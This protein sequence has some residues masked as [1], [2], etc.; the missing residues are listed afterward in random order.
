MYK[1]VTNDSSTYALACLPFEGMLEKR[2]VQKKV[3][4]LAFGPEVDTLAAVK[5][6]C[7]DELKTAV[8]T[9]YEPELRYRIL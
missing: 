8:L 6:I 5:E 7:C 1:L 2:G 9:V 4:C 3:L